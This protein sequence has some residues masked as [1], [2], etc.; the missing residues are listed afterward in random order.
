[1]NPA[2]APHIAARVDLIAA[3]WV[4]EDQGRTEDAQRIRRQLGGRWA[5]EMASCSPG[6]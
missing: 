6:C 1:M 5:K 2:H 4:A 3:L